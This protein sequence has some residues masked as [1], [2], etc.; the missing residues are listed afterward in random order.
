M[1]ASPTLLLALDVCYERDGGAL[2]AGVGFETWDAAA[3]AAEFDVRIETTHAYEPG[4]F[5]KRE[6]PC[7][8]RAIE[9]FRALPLA[10]GRVIECI[11]V[12]GYV[13][14]D[15]N[16]RPGLGRHLYDALESR[17]AVVGVAKTAF[18]GIGPAHEVLRGASARP[19][20]VTAAG[21]D[22]EAAKR[23]VLSMHGP[24]RIPTL[25]NRVD[26]L[27][28]TGVQPMGKMAIP[29]PAHRP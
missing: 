2:A 21:L 4:A 29:S 8:L 13:D 6:L 5:Y 23:A 3:P 7:L 9:A 28:R 15:A 24:H 10:E 25:L 14:L 16:G 1:P 19:L 22:L 11:V 27:S 20:F 17:I 26:R 18:A 12:D